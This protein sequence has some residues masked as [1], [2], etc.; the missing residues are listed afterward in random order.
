MSV[1]PQVDQ[2][3]EEAEELVSAAI[4]AAEAGTPFFD[5]RTYINMSAALMFALVI[6]RVGMTEQDFAD[7]LDRYDGGT[8]YSGQ[9][10]P[11]EPS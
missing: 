6:D 9:A 2:F 1:I 11:G 3:L 7:A 5:S 4:T 8:D 10:T